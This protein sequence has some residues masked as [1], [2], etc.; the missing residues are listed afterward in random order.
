[1]LTIQKQEGRK[2]FSLVAVV[3][4][5]EKSLATFHSE[6]D[7]K[8]AWGFFAEMAEQIIKLENRALEPKSFFRHVEEIH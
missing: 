5:K 3:D 6:E 4:G 1:M 7:V 8:V 2:K